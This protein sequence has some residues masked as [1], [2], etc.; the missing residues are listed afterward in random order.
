MSIFSSILNKIFPHDHPANTGSGATAGAAAPATAAPGSA[1]APAGA[2]ATPSTAAAGNAQP[3]VT[4]MPAVDVEAVLTKMQESS[5]EKLNWRTSIV[6]LMKLLG[7]D[8]SLTARKELASELHYTGNTED[9]AAM[10]IWLHK[11]V[12]QKLAENGGKVPDDLKN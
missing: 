6:D 4:P 2:P 8:S 5:G 3:P 12:M 10:N 9:S 11:Q 7:L 1:S